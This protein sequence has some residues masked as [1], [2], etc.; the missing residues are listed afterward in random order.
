MQI[1]TF[2]SC[3]ISH[4]QL[5]IS[6]SN[7]Y[8]SY[9]VNTTVYQFTLYCSQPLAILPIHCKGENVFLE[10]E[11]VLPIFP[12]DNTNDIVCLFYKNNLSSSASTRNNRGKQNFLP[13]QTLHL[14][15]LYFIK[16]F[17]DVKTVR[18]NII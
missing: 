4:Q 7:I 12:A 5:N 18:L 3:M 17:S 6:K 11:F 2:N 1:I 8:Y 10:T 13:P 14:T 9:Y 15:F 16:L